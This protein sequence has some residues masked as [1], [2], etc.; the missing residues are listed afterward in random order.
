MDGHT[1][2]IGII[3]LVV[4]RSVSDFVDQAPSPYGRFRLPAPAPDG[5]NPCGSF[6]RIWGQARIKAGSSYLMANYIRSSGISLV[7]L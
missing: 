6:V 1:D 4:N 7:F 2:R 5:R 3:N